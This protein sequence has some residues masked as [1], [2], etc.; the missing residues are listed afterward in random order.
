MSARRFRAIGVALV[1]TVVFLLACLTGSLACYQFG[2]PNQT[3]A[4]CHDMTGAHLAWST[5]SHRT[6][7]CR[8][9]HG[10]SLTLDI[11]ALQAQVHRVM[12]H[13][14]PSP[15]APIRLTEQDLLAMQLAC[16]SCHPQT[17]ADWQKGPHSATY[18]RFF[19]D[20]KL[21]R[22]Q[23][24]AADC[25]R[26]HGM[27]YDGNI[28]DLVTPMSTK[29]PWHFKDAAMAG[30]AAIPCLACHQIHKPAGRLE[31]DLYVRHEQSSFAA[32]LLPMATVTRQNQPVRI[33]ADPRQRLCAQCH[34][35]NPLRQQGTDQDRTPIGVH[36]GLS[37]IDCHSPHSFSAAASCAA[38]HP[39]ISHC[40]LDVTKMDTTFFSAGSKHDIHSVACGDC[41]NGRRP[42]MRD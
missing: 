25:L 11:H 34:A 3:C 16:Q 38:C 12:E 26:C 36:E 1:F 2:N 19:L 37:C 31:P 15:D 23:K 42:A 35:P 9:C 22:T 29:G 18:S 32:S 30:K 33:S 21:N 6:V 27:F 5:S 10:G 28:E 41:H 40:G 13:F 24:L 7:Q 39:A 17:F 14:R 4:S 20:A 8:S